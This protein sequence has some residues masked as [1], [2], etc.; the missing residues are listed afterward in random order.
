MSSEVQLDEQWSVVGKRLPAMLNPH[1][2][3]R[4]TCGF[5]STIFSRQIG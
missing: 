5:P 1:A 2:E 3:P 4:P